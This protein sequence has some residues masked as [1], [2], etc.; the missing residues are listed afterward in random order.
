MSKGCLQVEA[1]LHSEEE[2]PRET[3]DAN[4]AHRFTLP[5]TPGAPLFDPPIYAPLPGTNPEALQP[6]RP[7]LPDPGND[8]ALQPRLRIPDMATC[9]PRPG[10]TLSIP[11]DDAGNL[12]REQLYAFP[13]G[14]STRATDFSRA[15]G[16]RIFREDGTV[17][18]SDAAAPSPDGAVLDLKPDCSL[19]RRR[20]PFAFI[21]PEHISQ[22]RVLNDAEVLREQAMLE[23]A[24]ARPARMALDS[25]MPCTRSASDFACMS[26][27]Q[28]QNGDAAN[29]GP[30][31]TDRVS[32]AVLRNLLSHHPS[33]PTHGAFVCFARQTG[34]CLL[35]YVLH[36]CDFLVLLLCDASHQSLMLS[37]FDI[38]RIF[39]CQLLPSS[40]NW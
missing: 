9:M 14:R 23:R 4:A 5:S 19:M 21:A 11:V 32:M 27:R 7:R 1:E 12:T 25:I 17:A 38:V 34:R 26:G 15:R 16:H 13:Q 8:K 31:T 20:I 3:S 40:L 39:A 35:A 28:E 36:C 6:A 10:L 29:E 22:R 24:L 18:C 33:G 37:V 30:Q 2:Q